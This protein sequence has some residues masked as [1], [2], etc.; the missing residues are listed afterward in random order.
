MVNIEEEKKMVNIDKH[1]AM[2]I[3]IALFEFSLNHKKSCPGPAKEARK[4]RAVIDEMIKANYFEEE[5]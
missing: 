2:L 1:I 4:I 5:N 3:S